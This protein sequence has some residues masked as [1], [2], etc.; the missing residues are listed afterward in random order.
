MTGLSPEAEERLA[1]IHSQVAEAEQRAADAARLRDD[2]ANKRIDF[3]SADGIVSVSVDSLGRLERLEIDD[4]GLR[5]GGR[6]LAASVLGT[7]RQARAQVGHEVMGMVEGVFGEGSD[8]S[9][10][11]RDTYLPPGIDDDDSSDPGPDP[12]GRGPTILRPY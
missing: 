2:I 12:S 6:E 5:S 7:V 4:A 3:V 11:M 10:Q 8:L 1:R 9:T